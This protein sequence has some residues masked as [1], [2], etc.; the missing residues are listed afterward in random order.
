MISK[1][2]LK[3]R[4]KTK[5]EDKVPYLYKCIST[6]VVLVI[7]S[8]VLKSMLALAIFVLCK[9]PWLIHISNLWSY[10]CADKILFLIC[11]SGKTHTL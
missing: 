4:V 3:Q 6:L 1:T 7:S 11:A 10:H 9:K 8:N 5:Q 2:E